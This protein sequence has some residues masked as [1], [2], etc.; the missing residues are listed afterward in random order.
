VD[1]AAITLQDLDPQL[2]DRLTQLHDDCAQRQFALTWSGLEDAMADRLLRKE[3]ARRGISLDM[4]LHREVEN[5]I[6]TPSE[7]EIRGLYEANKATIG[8][9]YLQAAPFLR[10]QYRRDRTQALRRS[11]AD[12]LRQDSDVRYSLPPP[13]LDRV[14]LK[15]VGPTLGAAHPQVTLVVFSDFTCPYSAQARRL[16]KKLLQRYPNSLQVVYQDFPLEQHPMARPA[17]EAAHCALEQDKFWAYYDVLFDNSA[18]LQAANF[19]QYAT[20]T[21][22]DAD[23]FNRCLASGRAQLAITQSQTQARHLGVKGT[24]AMFINGMRLT[25]VLPMPLMQAFIDHE[26]AQ[27]PATAEN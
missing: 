3:A 2:Q 4:L 8:V 22:L 23:A 20:Q 26:L 17:A 14:A 5:R 18:Q 13:N 27:H 6:G 21:G 7:D 15:V 1:G 12:R 10:N 25:G 11:L 16:I 19:V 9:P 24:P